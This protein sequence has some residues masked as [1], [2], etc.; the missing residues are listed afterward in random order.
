MA[1]I[2][3]LGPA[4]A[5]DPGTRYRLRGKTRADDVV[6]TKGVPVDVNPSQAKRLRADDDH[7][8]GTPKEAKREAGQPIPGYDELNA[9]E[10]IEALGDPKRVN[11]ATAQAILEYEEARE[12]S[13]K[14]VLEAAQ[15]QVDA[16]NNVP[17]D[18]EAGSVSGG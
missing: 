13:R 2:V 3:Y 18:G 10:V 11:A 9:D 17:A 8:F 16:F 15:A 7:R 1:E 5:A 14:T 6:L 4:D 12:S